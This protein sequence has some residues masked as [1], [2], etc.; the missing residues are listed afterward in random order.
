M[1]INVIFTP[2]QKIRL[3]EF[4]LKTENE[5]RFGRSS[6][7]GKIILYYNGY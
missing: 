1:G 3:Q 6:L 2:V 4:S 5:A 7:G